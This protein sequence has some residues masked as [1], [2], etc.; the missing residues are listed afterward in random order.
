[1]LTIFVKFKHVIS[2][3]ANNLKAI[4]NNFKQ[5]LTPNGFVNIK[6]NLAADAPESV[7]Y[8]NNLNDFIDHVKNIDKYVMYILTGSRGL[9]IRLSYV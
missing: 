2:V 3:A 6:A 8:C 5:N 7:I 1:M 4:E 9:E